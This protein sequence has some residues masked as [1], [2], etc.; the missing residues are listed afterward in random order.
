MYD[1]KTLVKRDVQ[2]SNKWA[3]MKQQKPNV[4][5]DIAPLSVADCD[6]VMAPEIVAGLKQ[7]VSEMVFGY[8]RPTS[9]YYEA[10]IGWF[11]RRHQWTIEKEWIVQSP[12]VVA[13]IYNVIGAFTKENEGVIIMSPVYYPF[14]TSIEKQN[15]KVVKNPLINQDGYYTIDFDDLE[16]KA[17]DANNKLLILCSPHNPVGRVW[18]LDELTKIYEICV[19]HQVLIL[20][21]EIHCDIIMPSHQHTM[22]GL[23]AKGAMKHCLIATAPSKSFNIAGLQTSNLIIGDE[24]LRKTYQ[25]YMAKTAWHGL[26]AVGIKACEI[27]YNKAE[28]WFEAFMSL[29]VTNRQVFEDFIKQH[30]PMIKITPLEGTYLQWFDC[31]ALGLSDQELNEFLVQRCDLF[32]DPGSMFGPEGQQFQR[33]NL[34]TPTHILQAALQRLKDGVDQL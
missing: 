1:F 11:Q 15:R 13:A 32:L 23:V 24:T 4:G 10:V 29:I 20:S 16:K 26:N 8:T 14:T 27:A 2:G 25:D 19:K 21:D 18:T 9:A 5:D 28:A 33:M 6:L 34:A 31:S 30:L 7:Y 22:F 12:G 3:L 17:A